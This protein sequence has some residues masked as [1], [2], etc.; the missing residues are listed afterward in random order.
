MAPE[1]KQSAKKGKKNEEE[2]AVLDGGSQ[3]TKEK[4]TDKKGKNGSGKNSKKSGK[5]VVDVAHHVAANDTIRQSHCMSLVCVQANRVALLQS[6]SPAG[7][8]V[9]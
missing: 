8:C 7:E 6:H 3:P 9:N 5:D 2:D 1:E 4:D